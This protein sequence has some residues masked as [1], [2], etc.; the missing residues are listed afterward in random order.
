VAIACAQEKQHVGNA[1]QNEKDATADD[2]VRARESVA[3]DYHRYAGNQH[4]QSC[5]K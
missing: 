3:C 2:N 5:H 1:C 4:Y